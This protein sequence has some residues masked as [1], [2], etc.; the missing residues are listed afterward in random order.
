MK[1]KT[2]KEEWLRYFDDW[3]DDVYVEDEICVVNGK[4]VDAT[5]FNARDVADGSV[6]VI[7][8]GWVR[9]VLDEEGNEIRDISLSSHFKK[10]RRKQNIV[11]LVVTCNQ[12]NLSSVQE[13]I[14]LAGGKL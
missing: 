14:K 3:D 8:G 10:W 7:D 9:G 13:A 2:T 1:I 11:T 5:N 4:P 6:I 12:W